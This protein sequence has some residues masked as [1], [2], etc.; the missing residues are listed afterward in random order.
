VPESRIFASEFKRVVSF[1]SND[2]EFFRFSEFHVISRYPAPLG[3]VRPIVTRSGERD[4]MD[5][6]R[7]V[8]P[9]MRERTANAHE[10]G[11][12]VAGAKL[13]GDDRA[14]DGDTKA[15]LTGARTI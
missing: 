14:S 5:A 6:S 10:Q 3:G 8:R 11:A 12:L 15:G 7:M 1:N 2:K 9:A 4:A 13:A